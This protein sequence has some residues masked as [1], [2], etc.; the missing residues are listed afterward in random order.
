MTLNN[1]T[2]DEYECFCD[3]VS[4]GIAAGSVVYAIC[5]KEVGDEGTPHLQAYIYYKN[6]NVVSMATWERRLVSNRWHIE[7]ARGSPSD[8]QK[9]CSKEGD[10]VEWGTLPVAQNERWKCVVE[11]MQEGQSMR[12]VLINY[13]QIGITCFRTL[14]EVR[15]EFLPERSVNERTALLWFYGA[16]GT[17][18]SRYAR[19]IDPNYY[20]KPE[21]PWWTSQYCQ[22]AVVLMD[23]WRPTKDFPLQELLRLADYGKHHVPIK[24][25]YL[26]FRSKVIVITTPLAMD[27]T[28]G[29]SHLEWI[30]AENLQ[31]LR[32]RISYQCEF[33]LNALDAANLRAVI[34]SLLPES[35]T[36][37]G[38]SMNG[39]TN[40]NTASPSPQESQ[41]GIPFIDID[42]LD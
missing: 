8:N 12:D 4:T 34:A 38:L 41:A 16:P 25:G 33:P 18:K 35:V 9:Y 31:Q 28:F 5:G 21:G 24:G 23:D 14:K 40:Q 13:P 15:N 3:H 42:E 29:Q 19:E 6:C 17:G 27:A 36:S 39:Q 10:Y 26:K 22:Q 7:I 1:W 37:V 20:Q 2:S 32:R 30:A 11:M